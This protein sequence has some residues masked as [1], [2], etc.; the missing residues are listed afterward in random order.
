MCCAWTPI[1][2][3]NSAPA[4]CK[5]STIHRFLFISRYYHRIPDHQALKPEW[6]EGLRRS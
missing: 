3:Q 1:S 6:N 4:R 2:L 5:E